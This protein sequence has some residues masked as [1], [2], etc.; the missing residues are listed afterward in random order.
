MYI[1]IILFSETIRAAEKKA[2]LHKLTENT[3]VNT[4]KDFIIKSCSKFGLATF[5]E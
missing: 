4:L 2:K 3:D 1:K 5:A